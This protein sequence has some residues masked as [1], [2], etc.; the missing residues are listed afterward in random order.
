M[1]VGL[2]CLEPALAFD[3]YAGVMPNLRRLMKRGCWGPLRSTVPPITVPAWTT[4]VTGVD[5]GELGLYGFRN[6]RGYDSYEMEFAT[7]R[8]VQVPRLWEVLA[9]A[10]LRSTVLFVPQTYPPPE[11]FRGSLVTCFLTPGAESDWARP[12]ELRRTLEANFGP[13]IVDVPDFRSDDKPRLLESIYA[14]SRQHFAMARF[15]LDKDDWDFFMMVEMGPDRLHHAFWRNISPDHPRHVPGNRFLEAGREYYAY[16]DRELGTLV[17]FAGAETTVLVVSDHGARTMKGGVCL[18]EWLLRHGYLALEAAP[19]GP[20]PLAQAR[21]DWSRTKAWGE[22]G[23]YGRVFLNVQ[24]REPRG[25]I[26]PDQ[27]DTECEALRGL[28]EALPGPDGR[29]LGTVARRPKD[30]YPVARG[31][32]PDLLVFFGD[33]DWRSVGAVGTGTIHTVANDAGPD[34]ANHSWDGVLVASGA[35]VPASGRVDGAS[36]GDVARTVLRLFDVAAPEAMAGTSILTRAA[37]ARESMR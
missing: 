12:A 1:V 33:L 6:R 14:M 31:A 5:P 27:A 10:G 18:N 29:P 30:L 25:V 2:D 21:I 24:G 36:V 35:Q 37:R 22:G 23:Y 3:K 9:E 13:Y 28:L 19:E 7:A 17:E 15:L 8:A 20:T 26:L 32:P 11:E 16:I 4:M 34:D